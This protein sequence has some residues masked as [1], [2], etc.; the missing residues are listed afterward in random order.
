MAQ[1]SPRSDHPPR[2][3][4]RAERDSAL[5]H[6]AVCCGALERNKM[7]RTMQPTPTEG[8]RPSRSRPV[9]ERVDLRG[10]G[11][12]RA[13][14]ELSYGTGG[15]TRFAKFVP[16]SDR[17][18][19][20]R[21]QA[22]PRPRP[23]TDRR[24]GERIEGVSAARRRHRVHHRALGRLRNHG[25]RQPAAVEDPS[26]PISV[27]RSFA[28]GIAGSVSSDRDNAVPAFGDSKDR[29]SAFL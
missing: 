24:R 2:R 28:G 5:C 6:D 23:G 11:G 29:R 14:Y 25:T 13:L 20:R 4:P 1:R 10:A 16:W 15:D 7:A 21:V 26:S 9:V 22:I 12:S 8:S 18:Q 17:Q 27:R 3:T 19:S